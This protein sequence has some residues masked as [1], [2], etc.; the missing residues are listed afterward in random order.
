[1]LKNQFQLFF[2]PEFIFIYYFNFPAE[3]SDRKIIIQYLGD[4]A[5]KIFS[6]G[7]FA[8]IWKMI[9]N[10]TKDWDH[11]RVSYIQF[12]FCSAS[13]KGNV[14]IFWRKSLFFKPTLSNPYFVRLLF[15]LAIYRQG[16]PIVEGPLHRDN[17][18]NKIC[19]DICGS[20][21]LRV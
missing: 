16:F 1:M 5:T 13:S 10:L 2:R 11:L 6:A 14:S 9:V 21:V 4:Y 15:D 17:S 3:T 7:S 19:G 18:S 20:G 12:S 8:I